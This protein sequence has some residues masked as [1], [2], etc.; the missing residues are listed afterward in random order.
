V[1]PPRPHMMRTLYY[2]TVEDES[3][4]AEAF[5]KLDE[6]TYAITFKLRGS[7]DVFVTTSETKEAMDLHDIPYNLLAEEDSSKIGVFH[8]AMSR[9]ELADYEE[10][11]RALTVAYGAIGAAC[12][13][14][15]GDA[16]LGFDL[17]KGAKKHTYFTAPAG[18]TFI[19][20]LFYDREEARDFLASFTAN[21]ESALEWAK[22][23]PLESPKELTSFN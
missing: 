21:E 4:L 2:F 7:E 9:E 22:A 10:G 18:H 6:G 16:D 19:F 5:A 3:I 15:N 14:V 11:V 1:S 23:L 12:V 20:R 8:N 13:G 17:S